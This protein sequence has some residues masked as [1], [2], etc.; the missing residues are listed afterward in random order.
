MIEYY[1]EGREGSDEYLLWLESLQ[2]GDKWKSVKHLHY[3][4]WA[5][6]QSLEVEK[7]T[8]T[9]IV[10]TNGARYRRDSGRRVGGSRFDLLPSPSST[11]TIE[12]VTTERRRL[13][14]AREL[15]AF[16][17]RRQS[18][19]LLEAAFNILKEVKDDAEHQ[20]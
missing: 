16:P 5:E 13:N 20:P 14:L 18:L 4:S 8:K 2:P 1:G 9:Q 12:G 7:L 17:W 15:E 3:S 11:E 19:Q 10:L 6:I